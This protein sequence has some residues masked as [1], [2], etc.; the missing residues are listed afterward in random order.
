M[1][2][3]L[4]RTDALLI[5]SL[6]FLRI[7]SKYSS[8][9]IFIKNK[10]KNVEIKMIH[11]ALAYVII[12]VELFRLQEPFRIRLSVLSCPFLSPVLQH[13]W[14]LVL[15]KAKWRLENTMWKRMKQVTFVWQGTAAFSLPVGKKKADWHVQ[16][17][18][19]AHTT[20][21]LTLQP[22]QPICRPLSICKCIVWDE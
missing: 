22:P 6:G 15:Y 21:R 1:L 18:T 10:N 4:Q 3:W 14:A 19:L 16:C 12:G 13:Q 20:P 7:K 11:Q 2:F 9:W 8:N 5:C 17:W